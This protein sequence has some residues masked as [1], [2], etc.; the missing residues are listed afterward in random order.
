MAPIYLQN[1]LTGSQVVQPRFQLKEGRDGAVPAPIKPSQPGFVLDRSGSM[2][3]L[4]T[5]AISGFNTLMT[6][7]R[8]ISASTLFSLSLFDHEHLLLHDAV[9]LTDVPELTIQSFLC[10]AAAPR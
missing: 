6:E 8:A 5:E 7:Q 3:S 1:R 10:H 9:S 4:A 2:A